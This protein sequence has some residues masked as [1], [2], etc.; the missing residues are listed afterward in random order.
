MEYSLGELVDKLAVIH[1]KIWHLEEAV[2][3]AKNT[4][5]PEQTEAMFDQ[6]VN[7]NTTRNEIIESINIM[8]AR[9]ENETA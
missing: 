4:K 2:D 8:F 5:S 1:L 9:I 6:I 3:A 7:L